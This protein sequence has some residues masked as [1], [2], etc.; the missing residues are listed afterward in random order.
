MK[1][2]IRFPD[3]REFGPYSVEELKQYSKEGKFPPNT[4]IEAGGEW[5]SLGGWLVVRKRVEELQA[6]EAS[7]PRAAPP[8]SAA[9]NPVVE[10][11]SPNHPS[12]AQRGTHVSPSGPP[13]MA[14][15]IGAVLFLL[16]VGAALYLR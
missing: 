1:Y 16:V 10:P 9:Y 5:V 2:R 13:L 3:G 8:P 15:G 11:S 4:E 12:V 14:I 6:A 7:Q